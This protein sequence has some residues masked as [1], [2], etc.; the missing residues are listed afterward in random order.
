AFFAT[1]LLAFF[2]TLLLA[3]FATL[4][5]A[6][7]ATVFFDETDAISLHLPAGALVVSNE[8]RGREQY[9]LI[10]DKGSVVAAMGPRHPRWPGH[11]TTRSVP[12]GGRCSLRYRPPTYPGRLE[13]MLDLPETGLFRTTAPLPGQESAFP[14]GV[15]VYV[16]EKGG[17]KFVVRPGQNRNNRW[18]W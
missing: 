4:L 8:P 15:L 17:A 18:Y 16:G 5:L 11:R 2:A 7:F 1:L 6:F 9:P 3:F 13:T 12:L 14:K 10:S